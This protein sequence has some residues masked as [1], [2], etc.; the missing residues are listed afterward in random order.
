MTKTAALCVTSEA[1]G[2]WRNGTTVAKV[3]SQPDDGTPDGTLGKVLGSIDVS[4][5]GP[6]KFAYF[7][8]W[9][10]RPGLPVFT[11]DTNNDGTARLEARL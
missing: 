7:I 3:N 1:P 8:E 9:A 10:I 4:A 5:K 11:A 2:A 6:A